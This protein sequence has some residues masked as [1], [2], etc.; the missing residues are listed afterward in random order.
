MWCP[1]LAGPC[2][3]RFGERDIRWSRRRQAALYKVTRS[4]RDGPAEAGMLVISASF[5]LRNPISESGQR[6]MRRERFVPRFRE[7]PCEGGA[8]L[9]NH[10][11]LQAITRA[12]SRARERI[13]GHRKT[14]RMQA[15]R[16][17]V[18]ARRARALRAR[19]R[20]CRKSAASGASD[21]A[22]PT[23]PW[24]APLSRRAIPSRCD[25]FA[26]ASP[27]RRQPR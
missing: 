20:R 21:L 10:R 17:D 12:A 6:E 11:E 7:E 18:P 19:R 4:I 9:L 5:A 23:T 27:H 3:Q 2:Q 24:S 26:R 22:A 8:A 25:Q 16:S 1:A 14:G 13:R 15:G